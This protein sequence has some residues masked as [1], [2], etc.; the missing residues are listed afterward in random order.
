LRGSF[1]FHRRLAASG[2]FID[3]VVFELPDIDDAL[4]HCEDFLL[5]QQLERYGTQ[6]CVPL[7][8]QPLFE[9][10]AGQE[11]DWLRCV[12]QRRV[13]A[14]G[15][16]ICRHGEEAEYVYLVEQGRVD[17]EVGPQRIASAAHQRNRKVASF[18][19]GAVLGEAAF[20]SR[21]V[22]SAN[23]IAIDEVSVF[24][25][26]PDR[27]EEQC[28]DATARLA[29]SRIYRNLAR[30]EFERLATANRVLMTLSG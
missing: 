28:G 29:L 20:F 12:V 4:E 14:P 10:L 8:Q 2:V 19:G 16:L 5:R 21:G 3:Q 13:F 24:L 9:G 23:V 15:E 6:L 18:C 26:D 7:E 17:I 30:L 25:F 22:R 1:E 11:M 27:L